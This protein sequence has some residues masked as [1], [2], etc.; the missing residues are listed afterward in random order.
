M[1]T[2]HMMKDGVMQDCSIEE[3]IKYVREYVDFIEK[4]SQSTSDHPTPM[5]EML[6]QAANIM[7]QQIVEYD[8]LYN[9]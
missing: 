5:I 7:E 2:I 4:Y 3:F 9:A 8:T 1:T 6:Q